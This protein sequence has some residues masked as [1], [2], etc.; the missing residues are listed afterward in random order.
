MAYVNKQIHLIKEKFTELEFIMCNHKLQDWE[1]M[2]Q[3]SLCKHNIIANSTFS[4]WG[5]YL[6]NNKDKIVCI[7]QKWFG[8]AIK[9]NQKD[10]YLPEWSIINI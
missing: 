5:A 1:Q 4:W 6:N 9:H 3:M 2:L 8:P 10:L 7:P